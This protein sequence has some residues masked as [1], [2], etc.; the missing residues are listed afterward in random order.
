MWFLKSV[1]ETLWSYRAIISCS[2]FYYAVQG[3]YFKK[4]TLE[5]RDHSNA[6]LLN[7]IFMTFVVLIMLYKGG[8]N[9]KSVD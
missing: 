5:L 1:N 8:F 7:I 4:K 6:K 2:T 3:G 9:F